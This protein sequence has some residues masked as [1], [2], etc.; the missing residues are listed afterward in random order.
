MRMCKNPSFDNNKLDWEVLSEFKPVDLRKLSQ[1]EAM[2]EVVKQ[3]VTRFHRVNQ[4]RLQE[5][6]AWLACC[7]IGRIIAEA[8]EKAFSSNFDPTLRT[9]LGRCRAA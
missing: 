7:S 1:V 6:I 4:Y 8:E 9:R 2:E 3:I 5:V